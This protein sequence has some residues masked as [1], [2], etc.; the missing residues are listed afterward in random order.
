VKTKIYPAMFRAR[1]PLVH[2]DPDGGKGTN[3]NI[4]RREEILYSGERVSVPVVSGNGIRHRLRETAAMHLL[5]AVG[6]SQDDLHNARMVHLLFNGGGIEKGSKTKAYSPEEARRVAE[7]IPV[8][9]LFGGNLP[10]GNTWEGLVDVG[11]LL[12]LCEENEGRL[13]QSN[14]DGPLSAADFVKN[15]SFT[16]GDR[17]TTQPHLVVPTKEG[18]LTLVP[19]D[20]PADKPDENRMI[21]TIETAVAGTVWVHDL[22]LRTVA[23]REQRSIAVDLA[24]SCLGHTVRLWLE[25]PTVGGCNRIGF[26]LLEPVGEAYPGLPDPGPYEEH[27]REAR[28]SIRE[29]ILSIAA[30]LGDD[31]KAKKEKK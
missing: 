29:E 10:G 26:G 8:F 21:F 27:L 25:R 1:T 18:D 28:D 20:K 5:D 13:G 16:K 6:L 9:T 30:E 11:M 24:L 4:F 22:T 14:P 7:L 17:N 12:P 31:K 2:G 23:C 3:M 19:A 15:Q